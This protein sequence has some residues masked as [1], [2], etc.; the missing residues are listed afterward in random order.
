MKIQDTPRSGKC[1]LEVAYLSPYGQCV[2]THL[3]PHNTITPARQRMRGIFG[4]NSQMWS[5]TLTEAQQDRWNA[6][7]PNVMSHPQLAS[8]G[9]LTGQQFWQAIS[10]VRSLVNLP[11]IYE[12]PAPVAFGLSPIG[13][14]EITNDET[15]VRLWLPILGDL[16]E[17]IMVFGQEPCPSGRRKRRHVVF[18]GL[19]APPMAGRTEIT[20]LYRARFGDP[21]PGR[22]V[23][24]L[25][26]QQKEGWK[27]M[28]RLTHALVPALPP[29]PPAAFNLASQESTPLSTPSPSHALHMPKGCPTP[30]QG[31]AG[32]SPSQ[33]QAGNEPG[34]RG[35]IAAQTGSKGGGLPEGGGST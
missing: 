10:C 20:H 34:T 33:S 15:G 16:N 4:H 8:R 11:P 14:L 22:R 19:V 32:R 29:A 2:R 26:C 28:D 31:S 21:R 9:P 17:D 7:G 1:G 35:G 6:A 30:A 23:F 27:A 18:L 24:I 5:A 12:P 25:T 13:Q 3:I